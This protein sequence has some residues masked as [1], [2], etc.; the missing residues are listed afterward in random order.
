MEILAPEIALLSLSEMAPVNLF[1]AVAHSDNPIKKD[2]KNDFMLNDF[3][4]KKESAT[5]D[6][7]YGKNDLNNKRRWCSQCKKAPFEVVRNFP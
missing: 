7:G 5:S 2:R 1:C 6:Y 3:I 4:V